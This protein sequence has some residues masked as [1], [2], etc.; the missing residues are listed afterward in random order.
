MD[1]I[2]NAKNWLLDRVK[3]R[4]S[5]DGILLIACCGSVLLFGGLAKLLAGVGLLWG[6]YTFA[7]KGES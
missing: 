7:M 3:E 4:T 2:L 6:V 5:H 1:V